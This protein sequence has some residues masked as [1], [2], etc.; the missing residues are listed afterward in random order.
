MSMIHELINIANESQANGLLIRI[1]NIENLREILKVYVT[2]E[3]K[4]VPERT[5]DA[6]KSLL[7]NDKEARRVVAV[8][9]SFNPSGI[10]L[11]RTNRIDIFEEWRK[12]YDLNGYPGRCVNDYEIP[13][14]IV[15]KKEPR[16]K[17]I[18]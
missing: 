3:N 12:N 4:N 18:L 15:M 14:A 9:V 6:W 17:L 8:S 7:T 10:S 1:H 2:Q 13:G 11:M 5:R 16:K